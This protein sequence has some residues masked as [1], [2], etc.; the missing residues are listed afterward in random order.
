MA[1]QIEVPTL[2]IHGWQDEWIRPNGAA[3]LFD[4]IS[5]EHKR[6]VFQNGSHGLSPL[7]INRD[8]EMRWLDRWLKD[9]VESA[10]AAQSVTVFWEVHSPDGDP[11]NARP[12]W[13]TSYPSWPP[14]GIEW[15]TFY[16]TAEG[17][18]SSDESRTDDSQGTRTYV[19][20]L[21]NE[22]VGNDEQFAVAPHPIGSLSYRT[23]P[24]DADLTILGSPELTFYASSDASDTDFL[25]T[26]KDINPDG[27]TLF[28]QR[29]VLRASLRAIDEEKSTGYEI[30]HAFTR[31][32]PL[33]PG[34]I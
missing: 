1:A 20:P 7:Q 33:V 27:N 8:E 12:G 17:G 30:I 14:P 4:L 6:I 13:T 9:D 18:L 29:T 3:R 15:S 24:L 31:N 2:L 22:L 5:G 34:E 28:L 19:Y 26:L 16:L 25:F 10:E 23:A 32:E 11:A 21:G